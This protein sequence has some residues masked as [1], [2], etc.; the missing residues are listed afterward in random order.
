VTGVQ[1]CALPILLLLSIFGLNYYYSKSEGL[2][3][4]IDDFWQIIKKLTSFLLEVLSLKTVQNI[5]FILI[6]LVVLAFTFGV[7]SMLLEYWSIIVIGLIV[8]FLLSFSIM[9]YSLKYVCLNV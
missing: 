1:T 7:I 5:L 3:Q 8:L 2:K 4:I 9:K 6:V